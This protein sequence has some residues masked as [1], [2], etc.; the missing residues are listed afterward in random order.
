MTKKKLK[1]INAAIPP[2]LVTGISWKAWGLDKSPSS[3]MPFL[4]L[5]ENLLINKKIKKLIKANIDKKLASIDSVP[6]Y[7][8][9]PLLFFLK[10]YIPIR[11]INNEI[12]TLHVIISFIKKYPKIIPKMGI[13]YATCVWKTNPFTV[14]ILN[15]INQAKPVATIPK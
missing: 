1:E 4:I 9:I 2:L 5:W 11:I 15:L 8:L 3:K 14:N 12:K 7:C 6:I 10:I 13:R